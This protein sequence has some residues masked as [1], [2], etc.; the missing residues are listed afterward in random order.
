MIG[1]DDD[2]QINWEEYEQAFDEDEGYPDDSTYWWKQQD[3]E[4]QQQEQEYNA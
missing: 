3:D 4:L 1:P 2:F